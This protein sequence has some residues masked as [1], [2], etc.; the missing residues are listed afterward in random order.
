MNAAADVAVGARRSRSMRV[1]GG[2]GRAPRNRC[3]ASRPWRSSVVSSAA[4]AG[5]G[6][7][8]SYEIRLADVKE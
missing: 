4:L 1:G 8:E 7:G 6:M 3:Q 5:A 2:F